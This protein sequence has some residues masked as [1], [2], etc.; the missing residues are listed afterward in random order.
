MK[1]IGACLLA[2]ALGVSASRA[3]L[4]Y[5]IADAPS[6]A[7]RGALG[8]SLAKAPEGTLWFSWVEP[9]MGDARALRFST[10]D[11]AAKKWSPARTVVRGPELVATSAEF[12]SLA[13]GPNGRVTAVW[14][15][16]H[17]TA[18]FSQSS[19]RGLDWSVPAPLTRE[20]ESVE[21]ISVVALPDGRVMAA[22]LDGRS[23]KT[24][25]KLEQ[26]FARFL[27]AAEPDHLVDPSVCDCCP[28][29]LTAFPDGTVLLAYRGRTP[30]EI[31][32]ILVASYLEGQ[33]DPRR[34]NTHD[35]WKIAG[36]PVNGPRL[37]SDGPRVAKAWFTGADS[38]PRVLVAT[39]PDAGG[40]YTRA[41]RADLG[42]PL[43]R[44]DTVLLRDGTQLVTWLENTVDKNGRATGALYLRRYGPGGNTQPPVRLAVFDDAR[45]AGTPRLALAKDF[46][47]TP[48]QLLV[49]FNQPAAPAGVRTLLVTMPEE[50]SLAEEDSHCACAP[51]GEELRG[52]AVRGQVLVASTEHGTVRVRHGSIPGLLR[53]GER[54]FRIAPDALATLKPAAEILGRIE[55][56]DG[57]WW[58][59]DVRLLGQPIR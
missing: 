3:E 36:C 50:E 37:A 30:E 56:R 39:S 27:G 53:A 32:D 45:S 28:T 2:L 20:S 47:T 7:S 19:N 33:W 5:E 48:A 34:A 25:G 29:A 22:W 21:K 43:G 9:E 38:E 52:S 1:T 12:P 26:L 42:H 35:H 24:G 49:T 40:I 55:Q 17:G 10:F 46:D 4:L 54:D 11:L 13:I 15:S 31:R 16:G 14:P 8:A 58:L 44:V 51:R 59:F 57:V 18:F 41:V 6:P 23:A